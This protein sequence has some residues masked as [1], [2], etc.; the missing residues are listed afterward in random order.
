MGLVMN[1][2]I[3]IV[4]VMV[5]YWIFNWFT[6][7]ASTKLSGMKDGRQSVTLSPNSLPSNN[8]TNNYTYST[9][10]YVNDWN[11]RFGEQKVVLE[12]RDSAKGS[13]PSLALG[14]MQNNLIV[15]TAVYPTNSGSS[16]TTSPINHTCTVDNIP[17]QRWVNII[18]SLNGRTMDVYIN[19]KLTR[20]CV[21][22][23]VAKVN[24]AASIAITPNGG[25][26]G[27]TSETT[28][29][30]KSINPQEAWNIYSQGFGG[31]MLSN[32]FNKYRV[33]VSFMED[34]VARGSFEI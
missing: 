5:L 26:S 19:G 24:P 27:W 3:A 21:L 34:N 13:S 28:Y 16:G 17:L 12:R 6:G 15:S 1:I 25:F 23:G 8:N 18:V 9:W 11:Y 2:L 7:G 20:T 31:N 10:I 29:R 32:L 30:A 22:P 14:A 33:R 4:V